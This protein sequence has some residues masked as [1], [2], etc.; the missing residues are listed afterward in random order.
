MSRIWLGDDDECSPPGPAYAQRLDA[1]CAAAVD[2]ARAAAEESPAPATSASTSASRP[3]ASGVV[4]HYFACLE[5]G[6][7]RLA[8]GG[9][10]RARAAR[11]KTVTVDEA[12]L[13]PG[14]DALLPP[15]WV[16]WSERLLPG[17]LGVGDLL[18]T[19]EDDERLA[20]GYTGADEDRPPTE[21]PPVEVV[22][23]LG[24]GRARVLSPIGRDDAAD[25]WYTGDARPAA[26]R[27]PRRRRRSARPAGSWSLLG[28]PLRPDVRRLR[29]RVLPER[30]QVVSVDH[31][32]GA[33]SEAAV[34]AGSRP[35]VTRA[36]RGRAVVRAGGA[37]PPALARLGRSTAAPPRTWA[38][39]EAGGGDRR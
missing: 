39:P 12:V 15:E 2:L 10:R 16:P 30:R 32:C 8:L 4:T 20:P 27:S 18:P 33:H 38:T 35:D 6:L 14:D 34:I 31:G 23:E 24:L 5:P 28:G 13:L 21:D 11:S 29:Q 36:D 37:A 25:R 26:P 19:R 1:V 7:P 3:T 17:D 22:Y 9:H